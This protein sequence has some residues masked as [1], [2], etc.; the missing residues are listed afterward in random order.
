MPRAD[1]KVLSRWRAT[2]APAPCSPLEFYEA[3]EEAIASSGDPR[4]R[5]SRIVRGEGGTAAPRRIYLRVQFDRLFFDVSAFL[6]GRSLVVGY[7]LHE[8]LPGVVELFEEIPGVGH[9]LRQFIRPVTY[10]RV[11]LLESFQ[12]TVHDAVQMVLRNLDP[13][14][15]QPTLL[16]EQDAPER[17]DIW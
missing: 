3:V 8:D 17:D 4:I 13:T 1:G 10:Y 12:H 5:F 11:D 2:V 16:R 7:W 6:S 9:L 14:G 15:V